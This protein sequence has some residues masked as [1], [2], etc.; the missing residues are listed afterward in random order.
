MNALFNRLFTKDEA[1][2]DHNETELEYVA[3]K[4]RQ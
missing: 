3:G 2:F 4:L 1:R